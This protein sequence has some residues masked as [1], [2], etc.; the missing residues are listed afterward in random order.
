MT[1]SNQSWKKRF[2]QTKRW[3]EF[4]KRMKERDQTDFVTGAKLTPL[5]NLHHLRMTSKEEEYC[6]ISNEDNFICLNQLTHKCL[7][8]LWGKDWKKR[9][10]RIGQ[11]LERMDQ[12]NRNK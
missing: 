2:R 1:T 12:I 7:H 3:K 10:E 5:F 11:L 9:W 6:D 8:F 4:R